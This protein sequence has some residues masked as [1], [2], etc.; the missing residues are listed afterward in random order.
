MKYQKG[1][2]YKLAEDEWF[3]IP[4]KDMVPFNTLDTGYI[5]YDYGRLLVR[6]GYAW[7]GPSGP[8]LDSPRNMT[9][10]LFHDAWYQLLRDRWVPG[11]TRQKADEYFATLCCHRGTWKIVGATYIVGLEYFGEEAAHRGRPIHTVP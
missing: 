8:V 10:S 4:F 11:K 6:R 7:D 2:K 3:D 5:M 1:Y 9:P